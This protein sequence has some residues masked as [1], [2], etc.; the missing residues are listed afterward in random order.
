MSREARMGGNGM[1]VRPWWE[2]PHTFLG[3]EEIAMSDI[4][5]IKDDL[6][7]IK[8]TMRGLQSR[9]E[10]YQREVAED[11][12]RIW[13]EIAVLKTKVAIYAAIIGGLVS[14]ALNVL[15]RFKW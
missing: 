5:A 3:Y 12:K 11:S 4:E 10:L 8:E 6:R 15:L 7:D 9:I 2:A 1:E 13:M 14:I